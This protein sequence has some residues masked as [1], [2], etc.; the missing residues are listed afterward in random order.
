VLT[1][2]DLDRIW[3]CQ[4]GKHEAIVKNIHD[5]LVKLAWD[6][7]PDQLDYLF[8]CFQKSWVGSSKKQRDELLEFIRH[9]A[10]DD[11]EGI[12][13]GK[14]LEL[15]WNL[16]HRDDCPLD[17]MEHALNAHI[18]ILDYSCSQERE[19]Q[20]LFWLQKCVDEVNEGKWVIPALKHI[21]EICLLYIESPV[22]YSSVH[23][24]TTRFYYRNEII[25]HLD[26]N[27]QL[28]SRICSNLNQYMLS[29]RQ[30]KDIES[31]DLDPDT[32]CVDGKFSHVQQYQIRLDFIRFALKDGQL[33]LGHNQALMV[34]DLRLFVVVVYCLC[35]G[36]G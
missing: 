14:V 31:S 6:F 18:K 25:S 27:Y 12:M 35:L 36:L 9:L 32:L 3:G 23:H 34:G 28:L 22:N 5:L 17:T 2:E 33:W 1:L 30:L 4:D 15:L 11:K 26:Q 16:A 19:S 10:E 24:P 20:K 21:K 8:G 29:L 7:S 13:A